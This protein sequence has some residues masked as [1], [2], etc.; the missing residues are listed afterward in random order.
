MS[1]LGNHVAR[2]R[3]PVD[4]GKEKRMSKLAFELGFDWNVNPIQG[5]RDGVFPLQWSL[6]NDDLEPPAVISPF[7]SLNVGDTLSFRVYNFSALVPSDPPTPTVLQVLFSSA[8]ASEN[9]PF[10]P[11]EFDE[12]EQGSLATVFFGQ[13][14]DPSVAFGGGALGGWTAESIDRSAV[15]F[16]T[17][18]NP[19]RFNFRALLTVVKPREQARFYRI[20]PEMVIGGG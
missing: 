9:G 5:V 14:V 16:V 20:D 4:G 12:I 17:L 15:D 3:L 10:S 18:A 7:N 8:T 19:G 13:S 1:P 6:V 2:H 11:L